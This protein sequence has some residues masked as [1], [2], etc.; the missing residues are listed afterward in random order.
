MIDP[1]IKNP[2]VYQKCIGYRDNF[3]ES[4]YRI[5][6]K[7]GEQGYQIS[8]NDNHSSVFSEE[9]PRIDVKL[10]IEDMPK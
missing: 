1:T 4:I 3:K 9:I 10:P 5:T 6:L 8:S 7:N 2:I